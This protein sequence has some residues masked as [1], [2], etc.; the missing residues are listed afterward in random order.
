MP[1]KYYI[2]EQYSCA[3]RNKLDTDIR[4]YAKGLLDS[5]VMTDTQLKE[6]WSQIK[7]AAQ[8]Y[9]EK[10]TRV[11]KKLSPCKMDLSAAKESTLLIISD[12]LHYIAYEVRENLADL[13]LQLDGQIEM[14]NWMWNNAMQAEQPGYWITP[15]MEPGVMGNIVSS[16]DLCLIYQNE[17]C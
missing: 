7:G 2:R 11:S 1:K 10:Y 15:S 3:D 14:V 9:N 6:A 8:T 13:A 12:V 17:S 16:A 4:Q 5:R